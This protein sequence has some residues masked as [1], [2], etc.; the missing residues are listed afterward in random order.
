MGPV[1]VVAEDESEVY[2]DCTGDGG[3]NGGG[4][5]ILV[6]A[7]NKGSFRV[8]RNWQDEFVSDN[9]EGGVLGSLQKSFTKTTK[10][11]LLK[12]KKKTLLR[13]VKET[14]KEARNEGF[15]SPSC[16]F[17]LTEFTV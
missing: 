2:V 9:N 17:L 4:E 1:C 12:R 7:K 14:E 11:A 16:I 15:F 5:S 3:V 13:R 8:T 10:E 6:P